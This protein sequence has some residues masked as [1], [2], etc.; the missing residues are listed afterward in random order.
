MTKMHLAGQERKMTRRLSR[1][2]QW[3]SG[4][5]L[6]IQDIWDIISAYAQEL[7]GARSIHRNMQGAVW[8]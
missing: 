2:Q 3:L 5:P 6:H 7:E 1:A 8:E 4:G